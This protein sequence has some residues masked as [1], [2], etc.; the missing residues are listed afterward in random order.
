[1]WNDWQNKKGRKERR[2]QGKKGKFSKTGRSIPKTSMQTC[3]EYLLCWVAKLCLTLCNPMDCS[4]PGFPI[5]HYLPE[6]A[7]T[8]I[9]WVG[10]AIQPV[11]PQSPSSSFD[12]I[13]HQGLFQMNGLFASGGQSIG[14]SASASVLPMNIQD[15]FL[16][17]LTGLLSL[18]SSDSWKSPK[19]QFENIKSSVLSFLYGPALASIHDYWINHSFHYMEFGLQSDVFAS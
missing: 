5:L 10:D 1:M 11:H 7:E 18:Q 6:F 3:K 12:H 4:T 19:P 15:W 9:H 8:H 2:K 17:G 16:L 14:A 13:Q